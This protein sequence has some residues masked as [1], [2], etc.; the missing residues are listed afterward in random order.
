M[1]Y[2]TPDLNLLL[3]GVY[4]FVTYSTQKMASLQTQIT[5]LIRFY[6]KPKST[7][8][9]I[10]STWVNKKILQGIIN[11]GRICNV[12]MKVGHFLPSPQVTKMKQQLPTMWE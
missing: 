8:S 3:Q 2:S 10:G 11:Y 5:T 9:K 4:Y 12:I 7:Y 1:G 6:I